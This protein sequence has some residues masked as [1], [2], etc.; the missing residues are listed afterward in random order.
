MNNKIFYSK[1]FEYFLQKMENNEH[2]RYSRFNDGEL[3][4]IIGQS[5]N[6][7]NC[8]G[9]RYFPQMGQ[10][11]KDVLLNYKADENYILEAFDHWYY[12][13]PHIKQVLHDLVE[14]NPELKF[15]NTDFIRIAH[16][17]YPERFIQ[18]LDVLREK[19]VVVV[20]PAYLTNLNKHFSFRYIDVPLKNCYMAMDRIT[21]NVE[22]IACVEDDVFFLFSASMPANIIIDGF[23]DNR[24]TYLDWGSVWDTF[25]VSPEFSFIRQRSD[26][27]KLAANNLY[28]N[29][30]L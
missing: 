8:D 30:L 10:E 6:R 20:G 16:E 15:L 9:H 23:D 2:F 11:L 28:K 3:T 13:L 21:E 1:P 7:A 17:Q 24:N 4:A 29:Y 14:A 22:R 19:N 18:V 12:K 5:P 27:D 25:F 26:A